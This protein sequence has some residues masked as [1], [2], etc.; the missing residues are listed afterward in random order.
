MNVE[1]CGM[2]VSKQYIVEF[3]R[4]TGKVYQWSSCQVTAHREWYL[5]KQDL[6]VYSLQN[7]T[8]TIAD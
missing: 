6:S 4:Y 2:S 7:G 8:F 5:A 3:N 1:H